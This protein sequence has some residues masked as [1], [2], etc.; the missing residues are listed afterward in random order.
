MGAGGVAK[1]VLDIVARNPDQEI[2]GLVAADRVAGE[3]FAG[4]PILGSDHALP[5]LVAHHHADGIVIAIGDNWRR[6]TVAATARAAVPDLPFASIIHPS[7]QIARG[8]TIG[9]GAI[10]GAGAVVDSDAR[11]GALALVHLNAGICHDAALDDY[12]SLGPG[13]VLSGAAHVGAYSAIGVGTHLF[14]GIRVGE[15]TVIGAGATVTRDIPSCTVAYGTPARVIRS[16]QPGDRY[17]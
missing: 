7:V 11:V 16:R 4:Y 1:R 8:A 5:T 12:A 14:H 13:A 3:E 6:A 15:H 2:I 17:L 10:I 9:P